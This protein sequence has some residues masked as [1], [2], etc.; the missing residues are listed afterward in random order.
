MHY[1]LLLLKI[2]VMK[3]P[4]IKLKN[5]VCYMDMRLRLAVEHPLL[6]TV[7]SEGGNNG[8]N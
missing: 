8:R 4:D 5:N 2:F 6:A 3:S 7:G 1:W